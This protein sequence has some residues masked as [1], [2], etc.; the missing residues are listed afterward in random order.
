[1]NHRLMCWPR[2]NN[3]DFSLITVI[4]IGNNYD[5]SWYGWGINTRSIFLFFLT[6]ICIGAL[7]Q[8]LWV[9]I[10]CQCSMRSTTIK[11]MRCSTTCLSWSGVSTRS[12]TRASWARYLKGASSSRR[13]SSLI[14]QPR[15][16]MLCNWMNKGD[17][18]TRIVYSEEHLWIFPAKRST[19]FILF[20]D[21]WNRRTHIVLSLSY[22]NGM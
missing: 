11:S 4:Y 21:P 12:L 9:H 10:L 20:L 14:H 5:F 16:C 6:I 8:G 19:Y 2:G 15:V 18:D 3:Y 7:V 1:M 13:A 22:K 17:V